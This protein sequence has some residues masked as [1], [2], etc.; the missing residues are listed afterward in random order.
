M[1]KKQMQE[2]DICMKF[3]DPAIKR[4]K[5]DINKQVRREVYFTEGKK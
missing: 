4:A 5:W 3:I 2:A 1:N